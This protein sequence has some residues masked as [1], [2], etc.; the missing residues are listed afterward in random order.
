MSNSQWSLL[1]DQ[2]SNRLEHGFWH[3]IS[4]DSV[5]KSDAYHFRMFIMYWIMFLRC[6]SRQYL[7]SSLSKQMESTVRLVEDFLCRAS[8]PSVVNNDCFRS[9]L[10][11]WL[12]LTDAFDLRLE[13]YSIICASIVAH[14]V[15]CNLNFHENCLGIRLLRSM[16][17]TN[18]LQESDETIQLIR[19]FW[20]YLDRSL[21]ILGW[22]GPVYDY[23]SIY[24]GSEDSILFKTYTLDTLIHGFRPLIG[25]ALSVPS[26]LHLI[27]RCIVAVC[28][29]EGYL[30]N[31]GWLLLRNE[32]LFESAGLTDH[33]AFVCLDYLKSSIDVSGQQF[34]DTILNKFIQILDILTMTV[35]RKAEH[36]HLSEL[37]KLLFDIETSLG[38]DALATTAHFKLQMYIYMLLTNG[39]CP[40]IL[41][42]YFI[43]LEKLLVN[44]VLPIDTV[45]VN[46]MRN[47]IVKVWLTDILETGIDTDE[48]H[49]VFDLY[50]K[51]PYGSKLR[52]SLFRTILSSF[53]ELVESNR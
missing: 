45:P 28:M 33:I 43:H 9:I 24:G 19:T 34:S 14:M 40:R 27:A 21:L 51:I 30:Q 1:L 23:H 52:I 29:A 48:S 17:L 2:F 50:S 46:M 35:N 41:F 49:L 44:E 8:I 31:L 47:R 7:S 16:L 22:T 36:S 53:V 12:I 4:T 11:L 5:S 20:E 39:L 42:P 15:R 6:A 32:I 3:R 13:R 10:Y 25:R 18:E 26:L 38:D 37:L